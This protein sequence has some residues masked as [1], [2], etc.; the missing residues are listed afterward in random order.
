MANKRVFVDTG[1]WLAITLADDQYHAIGD[2]TLKQL[3][4]SGT[5]LVTGNHVIGET[6]TFLAKLRSPKIAGDFIE[7]VRA[8][9]ALD[10]YFADETVE[11]SAYDL[12]RKYS[13]HP[14]SFIDAVSFVIM[15]ELGLH[16][17]FAF[18][19]HFTTA[20]FT[21]IPESIHY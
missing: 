12:L 21:R 15:K 10:L 1:A 13:D 2:K 14:F 17:V 19:K 7:T 20:G 16:K 5:R 6:Y 3:L 11:S 4:A 9:R 8:S 18:D